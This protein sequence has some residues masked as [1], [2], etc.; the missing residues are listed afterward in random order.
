MDYT[1]PL[2]DFAGPSI[3]FGK[4]VAILRSLVHGQVSDVEIY[5]DTEEVVLGRS[6]RVPRG[7]RISL[8]LSSSIR[9]DVPNDNLKVLSTEHC[10][11]WR[12]NR[13]ADGAPS[14]MIQDNSMNGT[15]R[16]G[17]RL[18]KGAQYTL[19]SGDEISLA[20]NSCQRKHLGTRSKLFCAF[21][22][23]VHG[24]ERTG[25]LKDA[26]SM[27]E[28][29]YDVED[30]VLGSGGFSQVLLC[31]CRRT[32]SQMALKVVDK[33]K[34]LE[35]RRVKQTEL[36]VNS[37]REA[38]EQINHPNVVRLHETFDT[39]RSFYLVME[40]VAGGDLLD[41]ILDHGIFTPNA[42]RRLFTDILKGIKC[43]HDLGLAHRDIKPEN[44]LLTCIDNDTAVAK[45]ADMGLTK[46]LGGD[47][48]Y[49]MI[50]AQGGTVCG[51]PHYYA[52][53]IVLATEGGSTTL[54]KAVDMWAA[55]VVLY[56]ML[57]GCQPFKDEGLNDQILS[58]AYDFSGD[59][60]KKV[61]ST[62][63]DM[64]Q[65]LM[66]VN[67]ETRLNVSRALEHPWV[68][69]V[70]ARTVKRRKT[71]NAKGSDGVV[72][73]VADSRDRARKIATPSLPII[74]CG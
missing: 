23:R 58:A 20:I 30:K 24:V 42:S 63:R 43:L 25:V 73:D 33:K 57:C 47:T 49:E 59:S 11:I 12:A 45:L 50:R 36:T 39:Q 27:V 7:A 66:E 37:E 34:F 22:F 35:F 38:M 68:N 13:D 55:G 65:Q 26:G 48:P 67:A 19:R 29:K 10:R 31:R 40:F 17:K 64:V 41:R 60:W 46:F 9:V 56:I 3:D 18:Q 4:A 16:N 28:D 44:V 52:P 62:A 54:G 2:I 5:E 61:S 69:E 6:P 32:G 71:L 51:T 21:V 15:F 70:E 14:F 1:Q 74:I 8:S 53:E 72:E